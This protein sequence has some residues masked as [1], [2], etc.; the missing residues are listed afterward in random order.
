VGEEKGPAILQGLRKLSKIIFLLLL[1]GLE[2]HVSGF[3][4]FDIHQE[5]L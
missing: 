1:E 5:P 4:G 3:V 2:F